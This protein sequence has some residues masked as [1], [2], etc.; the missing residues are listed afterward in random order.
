MFVRAVKAHRASLKS[1]AK[2]PQA[3]VETARANGLV[4]TASRVEAYRDVI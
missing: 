1:P 3:Y 2:S 4:E